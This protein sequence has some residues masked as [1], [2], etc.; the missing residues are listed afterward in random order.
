[1]EDKKIKQNRN[2]IFANIKLIL[3]KMTDSIIIEA[4]AQLAYFLVI[5]FI[6]L[7]AVIVSIASFVPEILDI[8]YS[9]II[10]LFPEEISNVIMN[11]IEQVHAPDR[12]VALIFMSFVS[13]WF[14]SRCLLAIRR[15]IN[16]VYEVKNKY[17]MIRLRVYTIALAVMLAAVFVLLF[18]IIV[19]GEKIGIYFTDFIGISGLLHTM[20]ELIRVFVP[21]I[22]LLG[23]MLLIYKFGPYGGETVKRALPGAVFASLGMTVISFSF[24]YY[25]NN[26]EMFSK[27][28]GSLGG[29][30]I[31]FIWI[32]WCC[33]I[34]FVGAAINHGLLLIKK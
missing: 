17:G 1:M 12:I 29:I 21:F 2:S 3:A 6:S 33:I 20:W 15:G 9:L 11:I 26:F 7:I 18:V 28:L 13:T 27:L 10:P 16:R 23:I 19:M 30:F 25:V 34:I 5:A 8:I 32:Y 22:L 4:S 14:S 31:F 24:S